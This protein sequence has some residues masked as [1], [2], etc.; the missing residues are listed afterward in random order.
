[1]LVAGGLRNW[2]MVPLQMHVLDLNT[3]C[4]ST[5][6]QPH[7]EVKICR[8]AAVFADGFFMIF[9]G[10]NR[11]GSHHHT[12]LKIPLTGLLRDTAANVDANNH[13]VAE[14]QKQA[15]ETPSVTTMDMFKVDQRPLTLDDL[16]S[17]AVQGKSTR[18]LIRAL[19]SAA[20]A[21]Q[22]DMYI[23]P[24][25]GYPAFTSLF[26]QRRECCGNGCR[27][28]PWGHVNVAKPPSAQAVHASGAQVD[29]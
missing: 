27:H 28:C 6:G 25:S 10:C 5:F 23:D 15:V 17:E 4:W 11:D 22:L 7:H 8:H 13:A 12:L 14:E 9:G 29:W 16:P 1:M 19:H 18:Q 20:V 21:R 3:L 24:A 2:T 26:L